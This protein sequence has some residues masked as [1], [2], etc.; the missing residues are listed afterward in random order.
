[1]KAAALLALGSALLHAGWNLI[2]KAGRD[3]L[4]FIWAV[5][6]SSTVVAIPVLVVLGWPPAEAWPFLLS[7]SLLQ[8]GYV[9][10]LSAAYRATDLSVAY[11]IARGLAPMLVTIGAWIALDDVLGVIPLIG[12]LLVSVSLMVIA[13]GSGGGSGIGWALLTG[14]TISGYTLIDTAGVRRADESIR[15][16]AALFFSVAVL[17]TV[18]VFLT[19]SRSLLVELVRGNGI[20]ML[21]SGSL[22]IGAYGLVLAAARLGP[23]GLVASLRETSAI[24][25][26]LFGWLVLREPF[27]PRRTVSAVG[28]ALGGAL[29]KMG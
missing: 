21:V 7:S 8:L 27:G 13:R 15:Y 26:T 3:P 10:T 18:A 1:V 28:V 29:L 2:V 24:F 17:S 12:V 9:F 14:I 19:R 6:A 20:R 4:V 5:F 22:A 16:V 23:I 11:P 25:G